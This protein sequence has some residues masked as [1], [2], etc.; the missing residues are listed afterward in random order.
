MRFLYNSN[1]TFKQNTDM[2]KT[3]DE[4]AMQYA[5][6]RIA[7]KDKFREVITT[8]GKKL[9]DGGYKEME[10]VPTKSQQKKLA[11]YSDRSV[12]SVGISERVSGDIY[13]ENDK[14]VIT[15]LSAIPFQI[16]FNILGC[17]TNHIQ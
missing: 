16:Q 2:T 4:I 7:V 14:G 11:L 8:K 13:V 10:Y 1:V 17:I 12:K 6:L 15:A 5:E 3:M 9:T